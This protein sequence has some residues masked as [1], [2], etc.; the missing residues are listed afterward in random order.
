MAP[1]ARNAAVK[2]PTPAEIKGQIEEIVAEIE[3]LPPERGDELD[4]L[5][6]RAAELIG[7][8]HARSRKAPRERI[9]A[10]YKVAKERTQ[11]GR[12]LVKPSNVDT[13]EYPAECL[14]LIAKAVEEVRQGIQHSR[15]L[16]GIVETIGNT[17]LTIR[18]KIEYKG[19]PDIKG[20]RQASRDAAAAVW[21]SVAVDMD[22]VD[23]AEVASLQQRVW[24]EAPNILVRHIRALNDNREVYAEEF[25]DIAKR[26]PRLEPEKAIRKAYGEVGIKIPDKTR[27]EV[28][29]ARRNLS[30]IARTRKSVDRLTSGVDKYTP[31]QAREILDEVDDLVG[32]L[33]KLKMDLTARTSGK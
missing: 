8:L 26:F 1:T 5:A 13:A 15:Q 19:L 32:T 17:L 22:D 28:E 10:A 14:P 11:D 9:D 33:V 23:K 20:D 27:A 2:K 25:P 4:G 31:D 6:E 12:Q 18:L 29:K 7:K 3:E 24:Q 30:P 21:T 16:D